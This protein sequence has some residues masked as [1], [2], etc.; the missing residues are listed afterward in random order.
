M[1]F[2]NTFENKDLSASVNK[3]FTKTVSACV[4]EWIKLLDL[5]LLYSPNGLSVIGIFIAN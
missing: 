2:K 1:F 5:S 3:D 4:A